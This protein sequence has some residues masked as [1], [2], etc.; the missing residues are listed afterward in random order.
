MSTNQKPVSRLYLSLSLLLALFASGPLLQVKSLSV[1]RRHP[2]RFVANSARAGYDP[3]TPAAQGIRSGT[4]TG[5]LLRAEDGG[6]GGGSDSS[7]NE[8]KNFSTAR[9]GGR[10]YSKRTNSPNSKEPKLW[11]VIAPMA[12]ILLVSLVL[13]GVFG[14][15]DSY[16]YS[17]TS[18]VYETTIVGEG[19][20][21]EMSRKESGN[22][23]SNIPGLQ[24]TKQ[25]FRRQG[26]RDVLDAMMR[27][28][29]TKTM[30]QEL[31]GIDELLQ[32]T[33]YFDF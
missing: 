13:K 18:S 25:T 4:R 32:D 5:F 7:E 10:D 14:G 17:Y 23:R 22:V 19:G 31:S 9:I 15:G 12:A 27:D 11:G 20:R 30:D 3:S 21:V 28:Q 2:S 29:T 6:D 33:R 26:E 24:N 1:Q 8:K 16:Y